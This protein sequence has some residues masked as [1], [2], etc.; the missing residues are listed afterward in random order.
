MTFVPILLNADQA[1][2]AST[3]ASMLTPFLFLG[4]MFAAMYFLMIRPQKKQQKKEKEMRDNL[5]I[6]DQ[7]ITIGGICGRVM[8]ITDEDIVVETGAGR[9]KIT[10]KKWAV[11][12]NETVHDDTGF[13]DDD[14]DD[15][16]I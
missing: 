11:Q 12:V 3:L 14:D 10:M 6:G 8:K 9:H 2:E 13:D 5:R 7:I 4:L 1:A 16:D 15:D